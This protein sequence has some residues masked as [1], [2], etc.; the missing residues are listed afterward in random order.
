LS[1]PEDKQ[2]MMSNQLNAAMILL[3]TGV[4]IID[5][6]DKLVSFGIGFLF[7]THMNEGL[8]FNLVLMILLGFVNLW[9]NRNGYFRTAKALFSFGPLFLLLVYPLI[10]NNVYNELYFWY[11]FAPIPFLLAP[12]FLYDI[13]KDKWLYIAT[14]L[15]TVFFILFSSELL[16][17]FATEPVS[18]EPIVQENL[19]FYKVAPLFLAGFSFAAVYYL[20]YQNNRYDVRLKDQNNRLNQTIEELEST[21][22]QL[23]TNEKMAVIGRMSTELTHELNTPIAAIKGNLGLMVSDQKTVN[24]LW[25]DVIHDIS[26]DEFNALILLVKRILYDKKVV[27]SQQ[28]LNENRLMVREQLVSNEIPL[29][30]H[31]TIMDYFA[32]FGISYIEPYMAICKH[33]LYAELLEIA[34][35]QQNLNFSVHISQDAIHKAERLIKKLKT[36]SFQKGWESTRLFDL[37]H[38]VHNSIELLESKLTDVRVDL[39][40]EDHLPMLDGYPDEII[41]VINNLLGNAIDAMDN[42]G[43]LDIKCFKDAGGIKLEIEDTGGGIDTSEDIFQPFFTT[44]KEGQGT[45][46]GLNI[47]KKIIQKH[48]GSIDYRNG[49][50]GAIFSIWLPASIHVN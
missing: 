11:P 42:Q 47:C 16:G 15:Y 8:A 22:K 43:K 26:I 10:V 35:C 49:R 38:L 50:S 6:I 24:D 3:M 5:V 4:F 41:Q 27:Q 21:Q 2:L 30:R 14:I 36:Y 39:K 17:I 25:M 32:D 19:L 29:E 48:G 40:F 34:Y 12:I 28:K 46:L 18:I 31:R 23:I 45:G 44:K 20:I 9:F 33:N 1:F 37:T 13:K 7:E